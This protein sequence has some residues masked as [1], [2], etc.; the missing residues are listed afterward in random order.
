MS[1]S[2]YEGKCPRCGG[3]SAGY[4]VVLIPVGTTR[5]ARVSVNVCGRCGLVFY[6]LKQPST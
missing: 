2:E 1:T 4:G 3:S 6:E 5:K